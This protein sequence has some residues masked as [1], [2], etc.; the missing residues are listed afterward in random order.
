MDKRN[1]KKRVLVLCTGNSI[2]SQMAEGFLKKYRKN[3]NIE[4]AGT[5]PVGLNPLA[6]EVMAESG[7]DISK[8]KSKSVSQFTSSNFDLVIT[9]CDNARRSCPVF[10]GDDM[11]RYIHWS[12]E[13]P[14]VVAG[15]NENRLNSFRR[16]RDLIDKKIKE[17]LKNYE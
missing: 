16:T 6:A 13:D 11:T 14:S 5:F 2:R 1:T 15:S 9:V 10:P 4:S 7:I 3:W 17:F 8:N 12:F